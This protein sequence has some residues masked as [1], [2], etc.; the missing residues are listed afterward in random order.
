MKI[1]EMFQKQITRDIQ[2]VIKVGQTQTETIRQE[3]EEYVVTQEL[4]AHL[5]R[6]FTAYEK[7]ISTSTDKMGVWISGFFGSGK[8]HFLKILAYLL[9]SHCLVEN[10]RP[11]E[12]FKEKITH[13]KLM[14]KMQRASEIST[15]VVL[16]NIDSKAEAGFK[17]DK[18]IK[19]FN[20][21]FNEMRG[22]SGSIPWLAELEEILVKNGEYLPFKQAFEEMTELKWEEGRDELYYNMDEV[23][24]ALVS[25]TNMSEASARNWIENGEKNYTLSVES[26]AEK[27]RQFVK[28]QEDP[29]YKLVFA[30]DEIG[31]FIADNVQLM[32][33]LQTL[34]EDLGKLTNGQVWILVTSQQDIDAMKANIAATDFSKIQGRFNTILSLSSAN[35]DEVIK[36]RLLEKTQAAEQTLLLTYDENAAVL[37]NKI[38]FENAA[39]MPT[40][41]NAH[42]FAAFYP[43]IPYQFP[44][45]QKVFTAI[46]DHSSAGKHLADGERSLLEC[47]QKATVEIKENQVGRLV[48]FAAFYNSIE[49]VLDHSVRGAVSR[50]RTNDRLEPFDVEVLKV[51]FLIRYVKEMPATLK[52]ITTL[53]IS[54]LE[55]DVLRLSKKINLALDKLQREFLIQRQNDTYLFLTNEE[56]DISRE[57]NRMEIS[58]SA[59]IHELGKVIFDEILDVAKFVYTPFENN[60]LQYEQE[61]SAW[62]DGRNIARADAEI[63]IKI[64]TA[65]S[66]YQEPEEIIA[67]SIKQDQMI[68]VLPDDFDDEPQREMLKI[69]AFIKSKASKRTTDIV[70]DILRRKASEQSILAQ[71]VIQH[72]EE[73]LAEAAI[74]I[75]GRQIDIAG[76]AQKRALYGLNKLMASKYTKLA[77]IQKHFRQ[78]ELAQLVADNQMALLDD[79]ND[80]NHFATKEIFQLL[81]NHFNRH[82]QLTLAELLRKFCEAPFGWQENDILASLIRLLKNEKIIFSMNSVPLNYRDD[83]FL[84]KINHR[85]QQDRMMVQ[86]REVI[87][88]AYMQATREVMQEVFNISSIGDRE[89]EIKYHVHERFWREEQALQELLQLYQGSLYPDEETV[90]NGCELFHQLANEADTHHFFKQVFDKKESL[91]TY[92]ETISAV[93]HFFESPQ[94]EIFDEAYKQWQAYEADKNYLN[95]AELEQ[96]MQTV[97]Q[98]LQKPQPYSEIKELPVLIETYKEKLIE[99]LEAVARPILANIEADSQVIY[100]ELAD[101]PE[102]TS[103]KNG[104][105]FMMDDLKTKVERA[106]RVSIL[107]ACD[108]ESEQIKLN[109]MEKIH[110]LR[111]KQAAAQEKQANISAVRQKQ[112]T[113]GKVTVAEPPKRIHK[114][115]SILPQRKL[116]PRESSTI[117]TEEDIDL[118]VSRIKTYLLNELEKVDILKLI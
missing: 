91:L 98:I 43:F 103:I 83:T 66:E 57:I 33:N 71:K 77:F 112:Q 51:L 44:L 14:E 32:L 23:I 73:A 109:H 61:I 47:V 105:T 3:L 81:E 1:E 34:V 65:Y 75:N 110:Q 113:T 48:P 38:D 2:G 50:A 101:L 111:E 56:Q 31:Q 93:R 19:V 102:S 70:E 108:G 116:I 74:Y 26:F 11:V 27:V 37:K 49:Q 58:S 82:L 68:M 59:V 95:D 7:S 40:Y 5:E 54:N 85:S 72:L 114:R 90:Q 78:E 21:V 15:D 84:K 22:F 92:S 16:F 46:R 62:I 4:E 79:E 80:P 17:Q 118:Y 45:L 39:E 12:F 115:E 69:N 107:K 52:N 20:K 104:F 53:F 94:K 106:S 30:V 88:A 117:E 36:K 29:A 18:L 35:A 28:A 63:G 64:L 41:K 100:A 60:K 6:F 13:P 9:D 25:V 76:S 96:M 10:K 8:S 97:R 42:E 86:I 67:E 99:I 55:E 24:A 89:D 87:P